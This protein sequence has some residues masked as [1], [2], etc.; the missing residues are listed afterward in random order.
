MAED[1]RRG[2]AGRGRGHRGP[3]AAQAHESHPLSPRSAMCGDHS[4]FPADGGYALCCECSSRPPQPPPSRWSSGEADPGALANDRNAAPVYVRAEL[5]L[6]LPGCRLGIGVGRPGAPRAGLRVLH[7]LLGLGDRVP[8]VDAACGRRRAASVRLR[9]S[10]CASSVEPSGDLPRVA[11][12]RRSLRRRR[13]PAA[14]RRHLIK[15]LLPRNL[16]RLST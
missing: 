10:S 12:A 5:R 3:A 1:G 14:R 8:H 16:R 7:P 4:E 15:L 9:R 2:D 11:H 6:V 13:Y